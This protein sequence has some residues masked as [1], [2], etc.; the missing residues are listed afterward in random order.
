MVYQ[1]MPSGN[2]EDSEFNQANLSDDLIQKVRA[3]FRGTLIW[4]GGFDKKTAQD[5]LDTGWTDLIAFG[6]PF[7]PIPIWWPAFS[8]TGR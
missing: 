2:V 7:S 4:C 8:M 5:A 1:L 3:A 6:R